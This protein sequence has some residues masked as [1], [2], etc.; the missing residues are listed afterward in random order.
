[1]T[2]E[3]RCAIEDALYDAHIGLECAALMATDLTENYYIWKNGEI[4]GAVKG[5]C[6]AGIRTRIIAHFLEHARRAI[7][8]T[9]ELANQI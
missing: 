5:Y 3:T 6:D 1:M 8:E 4:E 2:N 9:R 7:A